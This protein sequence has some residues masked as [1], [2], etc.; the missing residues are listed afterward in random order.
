MLSWHYLNVMVRIE[1]VCEP[2]WA[3]WYRLTPEERW[4]ASGR[5]WDVFL[6]L[7]G[8]PDAEPDSQSPFYDA[9]AP[10]PESP[11]G[12]SGVRVV[13]RSGV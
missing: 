7:G 5:M 11:D 3:A 4:T 6:S 10:R 13:R 1:D 12:R 8:S 2:E 9:R